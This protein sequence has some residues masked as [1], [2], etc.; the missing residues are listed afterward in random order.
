MIVSPT[1]TVGLATTQGAPGDSALSNGLGRDAFLKLLVTQLQ[2]QDPTKPQDT[3]E[4]LSQL[5]QFSSL[6]QLVEISDLLRGIEQMLATPQA[7]T[8][9]A[10]VGTP[11]TGGNA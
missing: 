9:G 5:A 4:M 1:D 2:H 8:A 6:E 3:N 7:D 10:A 11:I